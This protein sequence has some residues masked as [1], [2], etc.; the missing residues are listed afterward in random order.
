M[1]NESQNVGSDMATPH[2][3]QMPSYIGTKIIQAA[4]MK[5]DEFLKKQGR[6]SENQETMG[7]GY[8]VRYED[9]YL[10]WSPKDVFERSYRE[11][12]AAEKRL[13]G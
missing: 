4:P 2:I 5:H 7:D 6:Y 1:K 3:N 8:I 13:I 9:G 12:T 10:S 11:I